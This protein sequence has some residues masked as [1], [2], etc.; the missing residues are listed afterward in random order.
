[1]QEVTELHHA[2]FSHHLIR[3]F[4]PSKQI[5]LYVGMVNQLNGTVLKTVLGENRVLRDDA[6]R[7]EHEND[8]SQQSMAEKD[9]LLKNVHQSLTKLQNDS[10]DGGAC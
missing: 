10:T 6:D 3:G 5:D 2:G 9:A 8:E 1:M 4:V 7:P